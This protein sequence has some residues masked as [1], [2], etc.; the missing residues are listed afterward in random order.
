MLDLF[1]LVVLIVVA[2]T[3]GA[4]AVIIAMLPG[5]IAKKRQH[6]QAEAIAI[7]G[8]FGLLTL[9]ILLPLA[10]IWAYTVPQKQK[11]DSQ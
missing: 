6:P 3:L 2:A 1:A 9:G 4:A 8:W 11:S 7:C 10:Y 5:Q